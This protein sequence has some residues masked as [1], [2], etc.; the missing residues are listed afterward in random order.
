M[1]SGGGEYDYNNPLGALG[2]GLGGLL[3]G[4]AAGPG[5]NIDAAVNLYNQLS[6]G[7]QAQYLKAQGF[8]NLGLQALMR[9][10]GTAQK[11]IQAGASSSKM[12]LNAQGQQAQAANQQSAINRGVYNTSTFDMGARGI[13]SDLARHMAAID[14]QTQQALGGLETQKAGAIAGSYAGMAG[15]ASNL[16]NQQA[17]LWGPMAGLYGD[18]FKAQTQGHQQAAGG[19]GALG[20]ALGGLLGFL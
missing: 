11:G 6:A 2:S 4:I 7:Q 19:L 1:P 9:G 13:S 18:M 20:G 17:A 5:P 8:Q 10:F 12:D 14:A 16:S 15:L 3:G